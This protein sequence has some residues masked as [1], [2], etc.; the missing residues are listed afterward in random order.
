MRGS[1]VIC[2]QAHGLDEED[3]A[4]RE[5]VKIDISNDPIRQSVSCFHRR[6]QC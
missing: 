5:V 3:L 1:V 6:F 4:R 2:C